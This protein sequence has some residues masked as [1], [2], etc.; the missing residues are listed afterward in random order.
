L[1]DNFF[2]TVMAWITSR[3]AV[4]DIQSLEEP[5]YRRRGCL[6]DITHLKE[7]QRKLDSV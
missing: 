4:I 7:R 2:E 1:P 3:A 5:K 6:E